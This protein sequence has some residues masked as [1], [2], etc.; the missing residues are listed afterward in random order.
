VINLFAWLMAAV[1]PLVK[2]GLVSLGIGWI[3]Y[4][5]ISLILDQAKAAVIAN[6]SAM[7]GATAQLLGH[8]GFGTALGII[9]GALAARAAMA[10]GSHMGKVV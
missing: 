7:S 3:A 10:A 1:A 2:Q 5:G 9:L 4:S 8:F 6:W